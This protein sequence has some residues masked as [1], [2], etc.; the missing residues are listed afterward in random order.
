M[1]YSLCPNMWNSLRAANFRSS[2][3]NPCIATEIADISLL[4]DNME[5]NECVTKLTQILRNCG[6]NM[7]V[8]EKTDIPMNQA[9]PKWF[10]EDCESLKIAKCKLFNRF[11]AFRDETCLRD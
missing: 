4:C 10:D 2:L 11:R 8:T 5:I 7:R 1:V 9:Q 3:L 6:K